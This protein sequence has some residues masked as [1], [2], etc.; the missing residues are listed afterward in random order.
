ME[1]AVKVAE[2]SVGFNEIAMWSYQAARFA[3][4]SP[5]VWR[6]M[7]GGPAVRRARNGCH[8]GYGEP[9]DARNSRLLRQ[10]RIP[11]SIHCLY[12]TSTLE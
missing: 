7:Q 1:K 10:A 9:C 11:A 8:L 6:G 2:P 4:A 12:T 5:A 3:T